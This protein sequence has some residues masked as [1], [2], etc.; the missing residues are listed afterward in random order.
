L[1]CLVVEF[2]IVSIY[3]IEGDDVVVEGIGG[4][5]VS[6]VLNNPREVFCDQK[7][8]DAIV[9]AF[10]TICILHNHPRLAQVIK[11]KY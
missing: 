3:C 8:E 10:V 9:F 1:L 2:P 11:K 7:A 5:R 6:I 4:G